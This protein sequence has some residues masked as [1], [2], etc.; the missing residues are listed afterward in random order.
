MTNTVHKQ[1]LLTA[2]AVGG[3]FNMVIN[4]GWLMFRKP[5]DIN[6]IFKQM[7][8]VGFDSLPIVLLSALFTGMVLALQSGVAS[9]KI[10]DQA[11]F[12]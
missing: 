2:N 6:N 5:D 4:V 8:R 7:V 12:L 3:A 9:L 1:M 10:F 11:I